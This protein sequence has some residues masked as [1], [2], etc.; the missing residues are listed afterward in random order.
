[1]RKKIVQSELCRH[2]I[3]EITGKVGA[4]PI[5]RGLAWRTTD[6]HAILGRLIETT[7]LSALASTHSFGYTFF[8]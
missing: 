8:S 7:H 5:W 3:Q 2:R 1:M 6:A 4:F